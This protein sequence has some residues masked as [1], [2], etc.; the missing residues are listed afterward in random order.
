M[1]NPIKLLKEIKELLVD[2]SSKTKS[3]EECLSRKS[4]PHDVIEKIFN[5]GIKWFDYTELS[6]DRRRKYYN[7]CRQTLNFESINNIKNYLIATWTQE[8]VKDFNPEFPISVRDVQMNINGLEKFFEELQNIPNPD[9]QKE[10]SLKDD[11]I[12]KFEA[13]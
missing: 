8:S 12:K 3:K 1:V 2:L 7:E 11:D 6:E 10:K 9:E 5:K 4:N 13:I